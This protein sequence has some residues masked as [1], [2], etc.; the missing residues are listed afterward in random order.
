VQADAGKTGGA[1]ER[2]LIEH[3]QIRQNATEVGKVALAAFQAD[4]HGSFQTK[5]YA[6]Q[7]FAPIIVSKHE[8]R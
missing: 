6:R 1:I 4:A 7:G 5:K 3:A 2:L 8:T